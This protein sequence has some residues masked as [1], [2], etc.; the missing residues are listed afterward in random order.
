MKLNMRPSLN[1]L[2]V[3]RCVTEILSLMIQHLAPVKREP[4]RAYISKGNR[5]SEI[6]HALHTIS[7]LCQVFQTPLV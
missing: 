6:V 5:I 3:A 2:R 7:L 4:Q 1:H